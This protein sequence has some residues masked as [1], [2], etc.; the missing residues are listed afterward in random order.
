MHLAAQ[1]QLQLADAEHQRRSCSGSSTHIMTHHMMRLQQHLSSTHLPT[2]Q[3]HCDKPAC[4]HR[5]MML[6]YLYC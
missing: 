2:L 3:V 4:D 5:N 6:L 1:L